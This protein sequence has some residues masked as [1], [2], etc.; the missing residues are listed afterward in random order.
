MGKKRGKKYEMNGNVG[1]VFYVF[2]KKKYIFSTL[3]TIV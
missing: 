1:Y 2:Y 3:V